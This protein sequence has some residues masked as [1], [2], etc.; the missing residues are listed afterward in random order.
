[1]SGST[2]DP[3]GTPS[4]QKAPP[5]ITPIKGS[6]VKPPMVYLP[7]TATSGVCLITMARNE[8]AMLAHW[9]WHYSQLVEAPKFVILD[10]ASD[11]KMLTDLRDLFPYA[12]IDTLRLPEGPFSDL[13]KANALSSLASI[14]TDRYATVIATDA[15]EIICPLG[16]YRGTGFEE[17][18]ATLPRPFAA[19]IGISPIHD[20]ENEPLFD[21]LKSVSEQ[22]ALG[23]LHSVYTK[24]VIWQGDSWLYNPGQ[25]VLRNRS[26]PVT[27]K[28]GL[29]HL[30]FVDVEVLRSR[31]VVR[32]ERKRV[33]E[34]RGQFG[35]HFQIS[36][37]RFV[38]NNRQL[39]G[40]DTTRNGPRLVDELESFVAENYHLEDGHYIVRDRS[41]VLNGRLDGLL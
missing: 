3:R 31:Q 6:K 33:E 32:F 1:M 41:S 5:G 7:S 15:D 21:P 38:Q 16:A 23:Q 36:P 12:D 39:N 26:V 24:P 18:L 19:P 22:R 35:K 8:P 27:T 37:S 14:M 30:K 25:H 9:I 17:L 20:V 13:Y 2:E 10:D 11:E 28:L 4:G 29:L 40:V 34:E